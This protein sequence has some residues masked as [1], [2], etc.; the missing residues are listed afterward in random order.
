MAKF[1]IMI[2]SPNL[3]EPFLNDLPTVDLFVSFY[4]EKRLEFIKRILC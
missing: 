2:K 3:S 4:K 1:A